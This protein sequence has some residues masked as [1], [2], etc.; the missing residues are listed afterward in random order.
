MFR[1]ITPEVGKALLYKGSA[2][3]GRSTVEFLVQLA[4]SKKLNG[5]IQVCKHEECVRGRI[6]KNLPANWS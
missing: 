4:I 6:G 2:S 3:Q 5:L 1:N